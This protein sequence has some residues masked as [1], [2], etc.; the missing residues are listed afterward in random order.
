MC[1]SVVATSGF[2]LCLEYAQNVVQESDGDNMF[3]DVACQSE[4]ALGSKVEKECLL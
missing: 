1:G 4:L 2:D 3:A